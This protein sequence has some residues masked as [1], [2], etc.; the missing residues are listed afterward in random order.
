[1]MSNTCDLQLTLSGPEAKAYLSY[2]DEILKDGYNCI[3][4][5]LTIA[6]RIKTEAEARVAN[7]KQELS[8]LQNYRNLFN[9]SMD[10]SEYKNAI[11]QGT[12]SM[13]YIVDDLCNGLQAYSISNRNPNFVLT[14]EEKIYAMA[15]NIGNRNLKEV[16][17]RA[18]A[19]RLV[20][21]KK[22]LEASYLLKLSNERKKLIRRLR[23]WKF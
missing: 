15:N 18:I 7:Y 16:Y 13:E 19:L 23:W 21:V 6:R 2:R 17:E 10:S 8:D 14:I 3:D 12:I 5:K 9:A 20:P 11:Y 22:E 4:D 1:M